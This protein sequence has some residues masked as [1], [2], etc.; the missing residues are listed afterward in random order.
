MRLKEYQ[1]KAI[2]KKYG[3]E[4]PKSFLVSDVNNIK[5]ESDVIVKAQVLIGHRKKLGLIKKAT[6]DNIKKI[7]SALLNKK[8]NNKKITD[9]LIEDTV[10][11]DKELY[12]ALTIDR[13]NKCITLLFSESGGIDIEE[14]AEKHPNKI[15]KVSFY[16]YDKN[17]VKEALKNYNPE[18][19]S[20]AE[21]LY[22]IMKEY[23]AELVEINPL[24]LSNKKLIALDSKII[25]D[26]NALFRQKFEN[27]DL[28]EIEKKALKYKLNY[29]EL[30]GDIAVI[31]NGAGLVMTTLDMLNHFKGKPADFLDIGGGGSTEKTEQAIELALIKKPKGLLINI[32]GGITKCDEIAQAIVDYKSKHQIKIP[33]VIR[34]TGTNEEQAKNILNQNNISTTDSM[35]EGAKKIIKLVKCQ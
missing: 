22:K 15:I 18:L 3:I 20:I 14:L 10:K 35:E 28:T 13:L 33:V 24:V 23:D 12:L 4:I 8:V 29:V 7:A 25:I 5:I 27:K 19:L 32:F 11:I 6:K 30:P 34:I 2:F 21:K 26:D 31:G 16:D 9:L 1:G 17:K